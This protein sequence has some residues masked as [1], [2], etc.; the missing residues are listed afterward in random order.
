MCC[1]FISDGRLFDWGGELEDRTAG[2]WPVPLPLIPRGN[3]ASC[4]FGTKKATR[5]GGA[6]LRQAVGSAPFAVLGP[7]AL[8]RLETDGTGRRDMGAS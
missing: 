3:I 4:I 8:A 5:A 6:D 7:A 2:G 1:V